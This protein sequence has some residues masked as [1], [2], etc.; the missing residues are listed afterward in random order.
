MYIE[1]PQAIR[2]IFFDVGFTLL[3]PY[4][5]DLEICQQVCARLGLYLEQEILQTRLPDARSFYLRHARLNQHTWASETA[6][7]ELWITYYMNMLHP[8][9]EGQDET[10]LH[11]MASMIT[12]EYN[13]HTSWQIYPDVIPTLHALQSSQRYTLGAISDWDSSLGTIL[14]NLRLN[15]YFDCLLV[16]ALTGHAK[17]SSIL[18][19]TALARANSI[20]DYTLHIGDSYTLDVLGARSVGMTPVLLDRDHSLKPHQVDCLLIHSLSEVPALLEIP[21]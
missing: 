8:F 6:I 19:E 1:Q 15:R 21:V 4:P 3:H 9:M 10:L 18:Y 11:L 2:T 16:S 12:R 5:S 17:P 13:F 14:Q 7:E 20:A